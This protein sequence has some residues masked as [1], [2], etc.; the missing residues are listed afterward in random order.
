MIYV[1][2][3]QLDQVKYLLEQSSKGCH[4]LFDQKTIL[5]VAPLIDGSESARTPKAEELMEQLILKPTLAGKKAFLDALDP[6]TYDEV[7]K[8]YLT[9]AQNTAQENQ[10]FSH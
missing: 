2:K 1:N 6:N 7:A 5:R 3:E 8:L 10:G 9:I 4:L